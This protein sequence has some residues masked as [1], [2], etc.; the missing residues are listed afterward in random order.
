[1]LP[2]PELSPLTAGELRCK[3]VMDLITRPYRTKLLQIAAQ[4]G[5]ATIPG[6]EMLLAQGYA[7]WELWTG[8]PAPK[9]AIRRAVLAAVRAE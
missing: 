3:L 9:A 4:K 8:Q 7:Q 2:N 1:M 5:I 6:V